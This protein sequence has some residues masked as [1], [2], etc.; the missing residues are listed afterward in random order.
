[1]QY[2]R[3]G[4]TGLIVSKLAFASMTCGVLSGMLTGLSPGL[5][6]TRRRFVYHPCYYLHE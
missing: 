1:M 3:L 2:T 4:K 5:I 6:P